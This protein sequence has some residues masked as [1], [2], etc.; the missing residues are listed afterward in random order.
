M[1]RDA[2][3]HA[4]EDK[5]RRERIDARNALD[6]MAYEAEKQVREHKEKIPVAQLNPLESAIA[7]ARTL[8]G[9]ESASAAEL[10]SKGEELQ[11][12]LHAVSEALYKAETAAGQQ[13]GGQTPPGGASK[14]DGDGQVVD[15]DFTEEK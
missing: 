11:R 14:P 3:S 1:V 7:S 4:G 2:E 5:A 12:A 6:A 13:A 9:N 8:L 10:K 15:A